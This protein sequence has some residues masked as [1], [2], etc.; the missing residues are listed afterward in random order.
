MPNVTTTHEPHQL[1]TATSHG[2]YI[3]ITAALMT[4]WMVLF[5]AIRVIV[6]LA[7]N[8][9]F[10]A[11]DIVVTV[12]T[13]FALVQSIVTIVA[14]HFGIGKHVDSLSSRALDQAGTVSSLFIETE[15]LELTM[16]QSIYAADILFIVAICLAKIS[17]S[18]LVARLTRKREHLV[19]CRIASATIAVWG[20]GSLLSIGVGCHPKH[21]W[22]MVD[23]CSNLVGL[24]A[25]VLGRQFQ[26]LTMT[27]EVH[28]LRSGSLTS[29]SSW[30]LLHFLYISYGV[31]KCHLRTSWRSHWLL[32][33][34]FQ[35]SLQL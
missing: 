18:E 4:V 9:F 22:S 33:A 30:A 11:D 21:P 1:I 31:Y 6:R 29:S 34:A 8:S 16:L 23:R 12:G 24:P 35:S 19:A 10:A 2:G 17:S 3:T 13:V 25:L 26:R 7:F 14:V 27:R 32:P 5:Y 15:V 28:G 20:I